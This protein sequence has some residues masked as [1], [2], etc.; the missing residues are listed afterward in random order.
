MLT[1]LAPPV[2]LVM[3]GFLIG[4]PP[5]QGL[6][7]CPMALASDHDEDGPGLGGLLNAS[8]SQQPGI[9]TWL[10]ETVAECN[11]ARAGACPAK[12]AG[13]LRRARAARGRHEYRDRATSTTCLPVLDPGVL[14]GV[15]T[16]H[17]SPAPRPTAPSRVGLPSLFPFLGEK[18][19]ARQTQLIRRRGSPSAAPRQSYYSRLPFSYDAQTAKVKQREPKE[20]GAEVGVGKKRSILDLRICKLQPATATWRF[21]LLGPRV[22]RAWAGSVC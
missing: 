4:R 2:S 18:E 21:F 5:D 20:G 14:D 9:T 11:H 12:S 1:G 7:G 16:T 10:Q 13:A 22:V 8:R 17:L 19:H 6:C 15:L 3:T